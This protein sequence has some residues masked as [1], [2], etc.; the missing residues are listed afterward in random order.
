MTVNTFPLPEGSNSQVGLKS[1]T[2][3]QEE[4]NKLTVNHLLQE[5]RGVLQAIAH[6][7]ICNMF[8]S[9]LMMFLELV[10]DLQHRTFGNEEVLMEEWEPSKTIL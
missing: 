6:L 1:F 4:R 2:T 7:F 3:H 5:E 9:T 8:F 10:I